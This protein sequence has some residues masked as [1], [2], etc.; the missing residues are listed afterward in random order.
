MMEWE[1][2]ARVLVAKLAVPEASVA[3]PRTLLPFLKVTVPVGVLP[4]AATT[5]AAN[6]TVAPKAAG[7]REETTVVVVVVAVMVWAT[8]G[9]VLVASS[10]SAM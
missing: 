9:E 7:L 1:P 3:V 6:L 8:A 5:V 10:V 2:A 4:D